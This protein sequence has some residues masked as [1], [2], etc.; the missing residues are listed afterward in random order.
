MPTLTYRKAR[1]RAVV[2]GGDVAL[3]LP[4]PLV[5]HDDGRRAAG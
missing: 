2:F 1:R 5:G 3:Q 4:P